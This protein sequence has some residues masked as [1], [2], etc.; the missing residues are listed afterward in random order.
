MVITTLFVL[1]AIASIV[2][3]SS[4]KKLWKNALKNCSRFGSIETTKMCSSVIEKPVEEV[5]VAEAV[6]TP[7]EENRVTQDFSSIEVVTT[8]TSIQEERLETPI[9]VEQ[10][11]PIVAVESTQQKAAS[12]GETK[13]EPQTTRRTRRKKGTAC[14][15]SNRRSRRKLSETQPNTES[16]PPN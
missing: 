6:Q 4:Y 11:A 16:Q 8:P 13:P 2:F 5:R 9:N 15:R 12:A 7:S 14:T 1:A 3:T 10:P